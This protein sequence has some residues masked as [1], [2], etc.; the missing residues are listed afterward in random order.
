MAASSPVEFRTPPV[1]AVALETRAADLGTRS[2]KKA[3]KVQGL[4]LAIRMMDLTT[5]EGMDTEGKVRQLCMKA[6]RPL[7]SRADVPS[8]AA[9]CV[10]PDLVSVA[11]QACQGST[12]QVAAVATGFPSGRT[13]RA[14]KLQKE[15]ESGQGSMFALFGGG[16][17]KDTS[18]AK[19]EYPDVESWSPKQRLAFEKECLGFYITGHPLDRFAQELNRYTNAT[20]A[21]LENIV[22][23]QRGRFEVRIGGVVA[24][25]R[26]KPARSG[27][28]NAFFYIEDLKGQVEVL[29]F[30]RT[31]AECEEV[32]KRDEP[33]L[34]T[35][36][37]RLEGE[38]EA[39]EVKIMLEKAV[40]LSEVRAN[41]TSRVDL[42]LNAT[43]A[44]PEKLQK[45]KDALTASPGD[46]SVSLQITISELSGSANVS[47]PFKV[48]PSEAL[49][50][51]IER[52]FGE[53]VA[54]LS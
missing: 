15:K 52:I 21:T 42:M 28:R 37:A 50:H 31:Y 32:L 47:L 4:L 18:V 43:T 22:S 48:A 27:G 16:P 9:V 30:A 25:L 38:G 49:L 8:C 34:L 36:S 3:S 45:L 20:T 46:C 35:G 54:V 13:D 40:L 33:V 39:F 7:P 26:E 24:S 12:V 19:E 14:T 23:N 51:S 2:I 10:Y 5:L 6:R 41:R 11:V 17:K 53:K 29:C 1:D 44:T